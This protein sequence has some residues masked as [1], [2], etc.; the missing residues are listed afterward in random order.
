MSTLSVSVAPRCLFIKQPCWAW[1]AWV[2]AGPVRRSAALSRD[3]TFHTASAL[4]NMY[5]SM[6]RNILRAL[7]QYPSSEGLVAASYERYFCY[8]VQVSPLRTAA[9]FL[10]LGLYITEQNI[11]PSETLCDLQEVAN[12]I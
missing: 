7:F 12:D 8:S 2:S 1:F 5:I 9:Y 11:V 4:H 10:A 3:N 6:S